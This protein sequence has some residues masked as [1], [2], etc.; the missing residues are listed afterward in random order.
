M[1]RER[2]KRLLDSG[3]DKSD[4]LRLLADVLAAT[5]GVLKSRRPG[6]V[7]DLAPQHA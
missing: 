7:G 5:L 6:K 2:T 4:P 1:R 3:P